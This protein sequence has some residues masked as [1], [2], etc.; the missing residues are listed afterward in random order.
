MNNYSRVS[1]GLN[2]DLL[3]AFLLLCITQSTYL[4]Y[5]TPMPEPREV[6]LFSYLPL[7]VA[8]FNP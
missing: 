1:T 4:S 2:S 3:S 8:L 5:L 7:Y 6:T